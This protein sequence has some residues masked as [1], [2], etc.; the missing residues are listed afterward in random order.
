M[1]GRKG[2]IQI[3][4]ATVLSTSIS[5]SS[6]SRT[7]AIL[8]GNIL[9]AFVSLIV[10]KSLVQIMQNGMHHKDMAPVQSTAAAAAAMAVQQQ[11]SSSSTFMN[12]FTTYNF[13]PTPV[14]ADN[15]T[16]DH[17]Y[18]Q[19][20]YAYMVASDQLRCGGLSGVPEEKVTHWHGNKFAPLTTRI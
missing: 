12:D 8:S 17:L 15:H 2:L 4:I 7:K 13:P 6:R 5:G 19:N 16:Y 10:T 3:Y 9:A 1:G 18:T 11:Q 20:P 14:V